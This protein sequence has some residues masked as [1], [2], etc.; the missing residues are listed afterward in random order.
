MFVSD[1]TT[2]AGVVCAFSEP[3]P[4][5]GGATILSEPCRSSQGESKDKGVTYG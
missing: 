5:M 3:P 4:A 1:Q 2:L